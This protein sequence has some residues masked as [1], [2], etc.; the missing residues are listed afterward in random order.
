[1]RQQRCTKRRILKDLKQKFSS[2]PQ[3]RVN[4]VE[5][6]LCGVLSG[7][8]R[9]CNKVKNEISRNS[10]QTQRP[11]PRTVKMVLQ[12]EYYQRRPR[13]RLCLRDTADLFLS[14]ARLIDC[15][16]VSLGLPRLRCRQINV[17]SYLQHKKRCTRV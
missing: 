5:R 6:G 9:T 1:M 15:V 12:S 16:R 2:G 14:S 10:Y 3:I 7:R 17:F 4:R 13:Q 8:S 11:V